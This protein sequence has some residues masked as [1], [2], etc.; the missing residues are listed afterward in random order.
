MLRGARS[1]VSF[2]LPRFGRSSRIARSRSVRAA[3]RQRDLPGAGPLLLF[4]DFLFL[5]D[6]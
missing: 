6:E 1:E 4:K 2:G 5:V 3:V